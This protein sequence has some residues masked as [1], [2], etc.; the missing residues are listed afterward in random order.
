MGNSTKRMAALPGVP[1]GPME[2]PH[3]GGVEGTLGR[4]L[5]PSAMQ[6]HYGGILPL[7]VPD[8]S[9]QGSEPRTRRT[10]WIWPCD[11]RFIADVKGYLKLDITR[12]TRFDDHYIYTKMRL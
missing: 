7:A 4:E 8:A 12:C 1:F 10:S 6:P 2:L 9:G 11:V 5:H 3:G